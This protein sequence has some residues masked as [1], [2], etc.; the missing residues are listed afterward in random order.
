MHA[1][2][3]FVQTLN[4]GINTLLIDPVGM[5]IIYPSYTNNY[6]ETCMGVV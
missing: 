1:C 5:R 6:D 3:T 2:M 4:L